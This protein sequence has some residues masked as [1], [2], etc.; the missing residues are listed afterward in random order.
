VKIT[1]GEI[2]ITEVPGLDYIKVDTRD[3]A[4][5][6]KFDFLR[7][8]ISYDFDQLIELRD[9]FTAAIDAIRDANG[10]AVAETMGEKSILSIAAEVDDVFTRNDKEPANVLAVRDC[11]G[12]TWHKHADGVYSL[13]GHR[14]RSWN[15]VELLDTY[16]PLTVTE[17]SP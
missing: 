16:G 8:P 6:I 10:A 11:E 1:R 9:A 12:D 5:A 7:S 3:S 13:R 2:T 15:W 4:T 17:V 14:D